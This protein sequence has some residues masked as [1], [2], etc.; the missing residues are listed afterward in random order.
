M[1]EAMIVILGAGPAGLSTAYHLR[2]LDPGTEV[3][4]LE[5]EP[6]SGG[7]CASRRSDGFTFDWTGHYL[8]LRDP[9]M[10]E[11][12]FSLLGDEL[13][14]VERKAGIH[15]RGRRVAF[16]FQAHLHALPA[17]MAARC[18]LDFIAAERR[19]E[20]PTDGRLPF[21][22]WAR[23][24]FGDALA[25]AFMLPYNAKL[26]GV[27][28]AEI[29]AEWVAWAVPRP[30]LEQVV[31]GALG[32]ANPGM[33][34]NPRFLYPRSGGIDRLWRA[35]AARVEET[36]RYRRECVGVDVEAREVILA[37][38]ERLAYDKLVST[39][40][41][42]ALLGCL[43]G[44]GAPS[45]RGLRASAVVDLQLGVRRPAIAEGAHWLYFP[46]PEYPFYRVGFPS[47]VCPAM[48]PEGHVS[49][50]VEFSCKPGTVVDGPG[51]WLAP[52]REGLERAGLLEASDEVVHAH[53]ALIDPAYVLYD[54]SRTERVRRARRW[55][56]EQGI[57]SIGRFGGWCYSYMER[58][59]LDGRETARKL[60][61][62]PCAG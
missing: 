13:M 35:L 41:L 49:L 58:A 44:S 34:Y 46:E 26:F 55:L 19:G 25:E 1:P 23:E 11:L 5:R 14:E 43:S 48:A 17:E 7:L 38:G 15:F 24:V 40:P 29:T 59:L 36:I 61:G 56:A 31:R 62:K 42:P 27:D 10:K 39:L 6:H 33:G 9:D 50:S 52:A 21:D 22:R 57:V 53:A 51:E 20:A 60:V 32:L 18:L 8:H 2:L 16:P 4:V 28:P 54:D 47:N 12:V 30:S 45:G 37:D 3:V